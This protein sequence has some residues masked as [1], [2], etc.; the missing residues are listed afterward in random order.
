M[1]ESTSR[2][3]ANGSILTNSQEVTKLRCTAAVLPPLVDPPLGLSMFGRDSV[4][5]NETG[6]L[7]RQN[8]QSDS[9]CVNKTGQLEKLTTGVVA[10]YTRTLAGG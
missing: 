9:C 5:R 2:N 8:I 3:Q 4:G 6:G 7:R 1:R 10:G